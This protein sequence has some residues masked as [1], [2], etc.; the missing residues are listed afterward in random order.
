MSSTSG[1]RRSRVK[2]P[3]LAA[4]ALLAFGCTSTLQGHKTG[5][6]PNPPPSVTIA[7]V[8]DSHGYNIQRGRAGDEDPLQE[9][10]DLLRAQDIFLF[11]LEGVLL[12]KAPVPGTCRKFPGQSSFYSLPWIADF[13]RPA[14][15]AIA[16]LANNHILD[17]GRH[18]IQETIDQLSGRGILTIGADENSERA[19]TPLRLQVH[20]VGVAVVAYLAMEPDWFSAGPDRAGAASWEG[21]A[22]E[23]R[24]A[25]LVA[26]GDIV[27]VVLHLHLGRGWTEQAPPQHLALVQRV[28]AAGADIVIAHGPHVPQGILQS[29]G[30]VALL[31]LGNFLFR[32]DYRMS[33]KAHRSMVAKM[34][35]SSNGLIIALSPLR[36]DDSGR[37]RLPSAE[38]ALKILGEI[39]TLS[40][41]LGTTVEIR[42]GIGYVTVPRRR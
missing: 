26:A 22:G 42:E 10:G 19:C 7:A 40:A 6:S 37:P 31:S 2:G 8:G 15:F 1:A 4:V 13:L 39:A 14:Q 30:G 11:N 41:A 35:I 17:C 33:E 34:T 5:P 12:S 9:V 3:L 23:Q 28:L 21:C 36:L 25:K 18:G 32:P 29:N 16:T 24:L 27:V 38:D 20:G